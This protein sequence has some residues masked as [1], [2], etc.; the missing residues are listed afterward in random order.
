MNVYK[1]TQGVILRHGDSKSAHEPGA[2][3]N[4][5][6]FF[7]SRNRHGERTQKSVAGCFKHKL[8]PPYQ[9]SCGSFY[10]YSCGRKSNGRYGS[11]RLSIK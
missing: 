6:V 1:I 4:L 2:P 8:A 9:N 5:S 10:S 7:D 3:K 11:K